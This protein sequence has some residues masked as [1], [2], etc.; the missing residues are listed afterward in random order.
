M[1]SAV[2]PVWPSLAASASVRTEGMRAMPVPAL[3]VV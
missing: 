1:I 3:A 2:D